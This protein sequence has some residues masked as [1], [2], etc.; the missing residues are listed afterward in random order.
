VVLAAVTQNGIVSACASDRAAVSQDGFALE[1]AHVTIK[2]NKDVILAAV[3]QLGGVVHADMSVKESVIAGVKKQ[4]GLLEFINNK[5]VKAD[6][7]VLLA[8]ALQKGYTVND[9]MTNK[10]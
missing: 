1:H 8:A 6:K 7:D 10:D 9:G 2:A 4:G 5:S 3:K